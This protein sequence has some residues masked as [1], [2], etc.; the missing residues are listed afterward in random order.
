[1]LDAG[2]RGGERKTWRWECQNLTELIKDC[3]PS[4]IGKFQPIFEISIKADWF[5][6]FNS[7][8]REIK[9]ARLIKIGLSLMG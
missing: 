7:G 5:F 2:D 8:C 4:S 3:W 9:N 1:M 6:T